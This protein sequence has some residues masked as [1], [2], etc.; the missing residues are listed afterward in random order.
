M[1]RRLVET[2][3]EAVN[4][5][6]NQAI[7]AGFNAYT[8]TISLQERTMWFQKRDEQKHPSFVFEK[9]GTVVGWI[10]FSPYRS[11]RGA[12]KYTAEISYYVHKN[13]RGIGIG[14]AMLQLAIERAAD[15]GFKNLVA[16]LLSTNSVSVFLLQK[17]GFEEWGRMPGIAELSNG[18]KAD[19]LYYG[20]VLNI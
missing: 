20:L 1:I 13:Y 12:L 7:V 3:I 14:S 2:D 9:D 10:Y 11:R 5:I 15:Y 18:E 16:I 17:F 8:K 19:H 4:E 6:Y